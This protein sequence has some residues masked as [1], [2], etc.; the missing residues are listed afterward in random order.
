MGVL[1][2]QMMYKENDGL[3]AIEEGQRTSVR[4]GGFDR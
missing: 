3:H 2:Y 4:S 1:Y